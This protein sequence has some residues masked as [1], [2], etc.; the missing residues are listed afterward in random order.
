M[1]NNPFNILQIENSSES[2]TAESTLHVS[3]ISPISPISPA[4]PVPNKNTSL[5]VNRYMLLNE[6]TP[7]SENY[8]DKM[9]IYKP[10]TDNK[11]KHLLCKNI[12]S[13]GS[14][15]YGNNCRFAHSLNEQIVEPVYKKIND[16][17]HGNTNLTKINIYNEKELY[18]ILLKK[19]KLC[20]NCIKKKCTGGYNCRNGAINDKDIICID[21][22]NNG[23][24]LIK[25]CNKIHLTEKGLKPYTSYIMREKEKKN[26]YTKNEYTKIDETLECFGITDCHKD[27]V[28]ISFDESIFKIEF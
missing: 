13:S 21:D 16:I 18:D 28:E 4:S 1:Y 24:C 19:C 2:D 14:C 12:M 7:S 10:S 25:Q 20:E 8:R 23:N 26:E 6:I 3:P 22:L 11:F 15:H 27:L 9:K 5:P 17:I